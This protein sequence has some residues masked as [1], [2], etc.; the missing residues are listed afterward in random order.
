MPSVD[1]TPP[2]PAADVVW[3]PWTPAHVAH[4]LAAV[5][6]PWCVAGGWAI[7]LFLGRVTRPHGD[8]EVAAPAADFGA[9]RQA[10]AAFD[11]EV[12]GDGCLWPLDSP[13]FATMHQ[14][15]V[16]ERT[17]DR[18]GGRVYRLDVFRE[19]SRDGMWACRRDLAIVLPYQRAV[20]RDQAGIPYLAPEIVLLFKAK[21]ARPKDD[22]D[23]RVAAPLLE[24]EARDWL[25]GMLG[26]VHPGHDWIGLL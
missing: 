3:D 6:A 5:T 2:R 1:R 24:P 12:A 26:R 17:P 4:L 19:P 21:A 18:P 22:A 8:L 25:R 20:R 9:V 14:T 16:S 15:W 23:F 13:Q 11:F 10:L 7:D